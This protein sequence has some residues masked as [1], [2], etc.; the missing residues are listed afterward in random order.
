MRVISLGTNCQAAAQTRR[1][2]AGSESSYFDWLIAGH[3]AIVYLI[4]NDFSLDLS[5]DSLCRAPLPEKYA[6]HK[7]HHIIFYHDHDFSSEEA[8]RESIN[9]VSGKYSYLA[10]KFMSLE[11]TPERTLFVC[12]ECDFVL[13]EQIAEAISARFEHLDYHLLVTRSAHLASQSDLKYKNENSKISTYIVEQDLSGNPNAWEGVPS[14][15][16]KAFD[17]ALKNFVSR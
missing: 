2:F 10:D 5:Y 8:Y 11:K 17:Y 7:D 4:R 16:D 13:F 1:R 14:Q 6:Q 15:W 9:K 12:A 3:N